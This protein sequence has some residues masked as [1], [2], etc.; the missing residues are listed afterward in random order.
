MK[1]WS[2]EHE[3]TSS[4]TAA[5]IFITCLVSTSD[6]RAPISVQLRDI[7][8][9]A[10]SGCAGVVVGSL[11]MDGEMD[12]ERTRQL[13]HAAAERGLQVTLHRAVDVARDPL[14]IVDECRQLRIQRILTSGAASSAL[15]GA[16]MIRSMI[17]RSARATGGPAII[18]GGGL[19][20]DNVSEIVQATGA[21]E[22]HGSLRS[23]APSCS[24]FQRAGVAMGSGEEPHRRQL[25][26]S[27]FTLSYR[28]APDF[29]C[30]PPP[31]TESDDGQKRLACDTNKVALTF[32]RLI[33]ACSRQ[34][35]A[36]V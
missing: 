25:S 12:V 32:S 14:Q 24:R 26:K 28:G 1:S 33:D 10:D 15:S 3:I 16:E 34:R 9:A 35:E 30:L 31:R 5:A 13:A 17:E 4:L 29:P 36:A 7:N 2:V 19:S 18:A 22:V 20:E 6:S 8:V 27:A 21:T 23:L 11:T